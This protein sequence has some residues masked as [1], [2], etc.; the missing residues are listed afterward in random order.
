[1]DLIQSYK[2]IFARYVWILEYDSPQREKIVWC[3]HSK[4]SL[5]GMVKLLFEADI[6]DKDGY[7]Q[8]LERIEKTFDNIHLYKGYLKETVRFI[9]KQTKSQG[10]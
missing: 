6:I 7:D 10:E 3:E 9:R 4:K 5:S 1:M 8:E 2:N